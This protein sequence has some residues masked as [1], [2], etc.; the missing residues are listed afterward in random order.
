VLPILYYDY[1]A[2][3]VEKGGALLVAA[4]P[5]Y[6]GAQSIAQHPADGGPARPCRPARLI[7]QAFYP[8]LTELGQ[9]HPGDARAG[10]F[11]AGAAGAGAAGSA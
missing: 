2:E 7:E 6:A 3:Y 11:G 5:E 1:I 10:G 4:G 9:R 8:R